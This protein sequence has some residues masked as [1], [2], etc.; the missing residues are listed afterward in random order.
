LIKN[1]EEKLSSLRIEKKAF[2][3]GEYVESIDKKTIT[4]QSS[5]DGRDISGLSACN[6]K[7]VTLAVD[8]ALESYKSRI[9]V[10]KEPVEKQKILLKLADLIEENIEELAL[11]D[12]L[13]TGRSIK[14]YYYDSIPKA[15]ET[16]RWF[17]NAV[18]KVYDQ[19]IPPRK[20]SFATITREPLG[21]VGLI[22]PWNDP[23]VVAFWKITPALLMGNSVIIKPAEQSSFSILRVAQ[24]AL[25]AGIPKGVFNVVPGYGHEAG[26]ALA[27]NNNVRGIFFTGSSFVGKQILQYSGQS[28][29]KKVGLECGGKSPFIVSN[30]CKDLEKASK[31]LAKNIFYNQ[32]QICSASSR[33]IIH[34]DIKNQF[35]DL[36]IEESK[37]YIPQN[38]LSLESEVGAIVSKAQENKIEEYISSGIASGAKI[39]T[40]IINTVPNKNGSYINPVI[41][42]NVDVNSKIVQEEI[43]GPI[44]VVLTV[45]NIQEALKVANDSKYGLAAS[46]WTNDYDEA[47]Q[48]SR[49]LEAGIV[50]INS[51][52]DDD[53]MVP[54]GGVKESGLGKDKSIYAF[55]EYSN[56]KTIWMNFESN[57]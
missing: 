30:K 7:D 17:A 54:F 53:N 8:F 49:L 39:I 50:H 36:L 11:L 13:E 57:I 21:V 52:G 20:N 35:L 18:D 51:Y 27:L 26:K 12:T 47:Y 25:E 6:E 5:I 41:F 3:N 16:I 24:L 34:K 45:Q 38:P 14:N 42:D 43:F 2:I 22:T 23:L 15:V 40:D 31:I 10:D 19:A 29:M 37:K 44:L 32:G 33:L 48:V 56:L 46:I 1:I 28:N 55:D 9:W 4:K